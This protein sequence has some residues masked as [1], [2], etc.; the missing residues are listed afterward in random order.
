MKM[1]TTHFV[2][3][4]V[5]YMCTG[6]TKSKCKKGVKRDIE[7]DFQGQHFFIPVYST[8]HEE[9][10]SQRDHWSHVTSLGRDVKVLIIP[11]LV[12]C[13]MCLHS[14]DRCRENS[15]YCCT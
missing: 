5:G 3:I 2:E 7:H 13:T 6:R 1:Y 11:K 9:Q 10:N 4:Y 12:L 15:S 14:A 8:R